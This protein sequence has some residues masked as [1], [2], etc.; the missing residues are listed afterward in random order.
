M[1]IDAAERFKKMS[2]E[3]QNEAMDEAKK[4]EPLF[5]KD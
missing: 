4:L 1:I 5:P 3:E 2:A